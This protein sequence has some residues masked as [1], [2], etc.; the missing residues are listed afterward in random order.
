M[1]AVGLEFDSFGLQGVT[2]AT[3]K[4]FPLLFA[5][6][7]MGVKDEV[8]EYLLE[9]GKGTAG[10]IAKEL[11]K[12]RTNIVP[13]LNAEDFVKLPKTGKEQYYGVRE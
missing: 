12:K 1:S 7:N 3:E 4:D 6:R 9:H 8:K 11:N 13:I 2:K 5:S 10:E